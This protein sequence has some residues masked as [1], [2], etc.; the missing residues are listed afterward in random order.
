MDIEPNLK[1]LYANLKRLNIGDYLYTKE[2]EL[3]TIEND[4]DD[5]WKACVKAVSQQNNVVILGHHDTDDD[6]KAFLYLMTLWYE[7][8]CDTF[9]N[10]ITTILL[11]FAKWHSTKLDFS[12]LHH[13]LKQLGFKGKNLL[14][15]TNKARIIRDSKPEKIEEQIIKTNNTPKIKANSKK[16]SLKMFCIWDNF[17]WI[18][19]KIQ[20]TAWP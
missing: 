5:A 20:K 7:Q 9:D 14:S 8:E 10:F 4:I 6:E 1:P 18:C 19:R 15:F 13:N 11:N 2:F 3:F 17:T 16:V 12:S